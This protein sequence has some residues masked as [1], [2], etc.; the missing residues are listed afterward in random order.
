MIAGLRRACAVLGAVVTVVIGTTEPAAAHGGGS[1]GP[2]ATNFRTTITSLV[3][4][5]D[6]VTV[7]VIDVGSRLEL[8]VSNGREVVVLGYEDEPYLKVAQD[9]V[10]QNLRSPA[11]YL[12]ESRNGGDPVPATADATGA[13]EWKRVSGG[14]TVR[15]HDHRAHWMGEQRPPGVDD[16]VEAA[17]VI[18]PAWTV[19]LRVDGVPMVLTGQLAWVPP[20]NVAMWL[21]ATLLAAAAF[22]LALVRG[23]RLLPLVLAGAAV[24]V[25]AVVTMGEVLASPDTVL[26]RVLFFGWTPLALLGIWRMAIAAQRRRSGPVPAALVTAFV[27]AMMSGFDRENRADRLGSWTNSLLAT[28]LP[29]TLTRCAVALGMAVAGALSVKFAMDLRRQPPPEFAPISAASA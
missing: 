24:A 11:T 16:S 3:P 2:T 10:F 9:G 20:P 5:V 4:E 22:A 27:L 26:N 8:R 13:P 18:Y 21:V 19:P 23:G 17:Q 15:W 1:E 25:D 7:R 28:V 6:G 29:G 12:N 14:A